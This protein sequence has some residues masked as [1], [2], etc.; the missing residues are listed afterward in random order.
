[1]INAASNTVKKGYNLATNNCT[2]V[3]S[4][5]LKAGGLKDGDTTNHGSVE[6]PY[7]GK[8]NASTRNVL[9]STKQREIEKKNTGTRVD[10]VL[11]PTE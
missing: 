2:D 5:A 6:I 1:M 10:N 3:P 11:K 4:K 8:F 9:P 7:L